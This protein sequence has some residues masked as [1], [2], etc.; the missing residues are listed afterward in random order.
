M[1]Q[2]TPSQ[3]VGPFF[4]YGLTPERY[5]HQGAAGELLV[6]PDV[7]GQHI[8][9]T[10]RVLDGQDLPVS[11]ALLELWQADAHGRYRHPADG[12]AADFHGFGRAATD[13]QGVYRFQTVKP[14]RVV[15]ADAR[16]QAPHLNLLVFARGMLSHAYTRAYFADEP[17]NAED[18]VLKTVQA[19]RRATLLAQP[20]PATTPM[21]YRFDIR[22]Q[23]TAETVFFDA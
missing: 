12:R 20:R 22:L 21:L 14:G 13:A 8:V 4:A 3:T 5:G 16:L 18:A 17:S 10:G 7:P 9:L 2:Q 19:T 1:R 15:G 6:Q 23:G 11:D